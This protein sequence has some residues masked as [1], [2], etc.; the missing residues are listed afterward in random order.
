MVDAS[1]KEATKISLS[2][3][4]SILMATLA[5]TFISMNILPIW[6]LTIVI[7]IL[8]Y[9]SSIIWSSIFQYISCNKVDIKA[10]AIS[11]TFIALTNFVVTFILY[12]E[13]IPFLKRLFGTYAPR[14]PVSGLPYKPDSDEYIEGMKNE[15]H[16]KIQ[17][18]SS[19]V[20]AV[21]PIYVSDNTKTGIVY[22]YW[23][24]WMTM[25]PLYF[26]LSL[27]GMC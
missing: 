26:T 7:P 4:S 16:Y 6:S 15:N 20:K 19:I 5:M 21:I 27:Q 8:I 2:V 23:I 24:F 25:L 14:N 10:I 1:S 18:L 13:N 9:A 12:L 3:I 11:N 17:L 22:F